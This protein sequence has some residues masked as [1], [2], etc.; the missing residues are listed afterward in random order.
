VIARGLLPLAISIVSLS[1]SAQADSAAVKRAVDHAGAALDSARRASRTPLVGIQSVEVAYG[2][3][4][5]LLREHDYARAQRLAET[6][7]QLARCG[8]CGTMEI[9]PH[10]DSIPFGVTPIGAG[11]SPIKPALYSP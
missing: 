10:I 5:A 11:V 4:V 1:A 3:A 7:L 2:V 6:A 8:G 9:G